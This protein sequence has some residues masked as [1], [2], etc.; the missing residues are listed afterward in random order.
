MK[1]RIKFLG[2]PLSENMAHPMSVES[3]MARIEQLLAAEPWLFPET[4][5][6]LTRGNSREKNRRKWPISAT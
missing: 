3:R 2:K 1:K 5:V 6:R 4:I